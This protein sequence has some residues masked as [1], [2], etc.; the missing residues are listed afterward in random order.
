MIANGSIPCE[1][2]GAITVRLTLLDVL[3]VNTSCVQSINLTD[4]S[5]QT[6]YIRVVNNIIM[7][8]KVF[9]ETDPP[10]LWASVDPY[11]RLVTS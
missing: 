11:R 2:L 10:G 5:S 4:A 7:V 9:L 6:L 8:L 3:C 1:V